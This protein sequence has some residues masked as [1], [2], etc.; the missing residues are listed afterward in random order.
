MDAYVLVLHMYVAMQ[1]IV[2]RNFLTL[3]TYLVKRFGK[4]IADED[5]CAKAEILAGLLHFLV[6]CSLLLVPA[7]S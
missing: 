7:R 3:E 4:F 2:C 5:D 6:L 1:A